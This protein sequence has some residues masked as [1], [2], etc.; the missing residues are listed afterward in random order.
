[1]GGIPTFQDRWRSKAILVPLYNLVYHDAVI[2]A[3][4]SRDEK[5][6]LQGILF[7][8]V[9]ELPI[10][11]NTVNEKTM[12]LIRQMAALHKRI[13]LLEMTK[14]EFL[15]DKYRKERTTFAD[16]TTVTV[17]WDAMSVSIQPELRW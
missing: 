1:V 7:G 13:G 4:N 8:G 14:H 16:G 9:P 2:V 5:S 17:D 11:Q 15:D 10:V 3:F 12:T 6:L